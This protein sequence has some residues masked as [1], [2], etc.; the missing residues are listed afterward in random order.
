MAEEEEE[1]IAPPKGLV[2]RMEKD[3]FYRLR[4][5]KHDLKKAEKG[6]R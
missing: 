6:R 1:D 5:K 4:K 2:G 3:G